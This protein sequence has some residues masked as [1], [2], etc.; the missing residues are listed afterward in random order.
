MERELRAAWTEFPDSLTAA[1]SWASFLVNN[2]RPDE[3]ITVI[4]Q[5]LATQ[6]ENL[7]ALFWL[8]R[9]TT[10]AGK[11]LDRGEKALRTILA[12]NQLGIDGN[13]TAANVQF[14]LG[15]LLA[16]KG[17][18]P[19]AR[20]ALETALRLNPKLDQARKALKEL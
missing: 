5:S 19:G 7:V 16:K 18:K 13:P 1:T 6:K 8:G 12:S 9:V 20:Q 14:R 15:E 3:A 11:Q 17:D 2:H 4:D 10:A